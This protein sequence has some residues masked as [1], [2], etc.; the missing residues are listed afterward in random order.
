MT[1]LTAF[2]AYDVRGRIPSELNDDLAYRIGR[3]YAG[4]VAPRRVVVGRD[5]RLS[6]AQLCTALIRG[7]TESGVEVHDIGLCGTEGVYFATFDGGFDGGIM[8]TASHKPTDYNGMKFVRE[9]SKPISADSGLEQMAQAILTDQLPP[10]AA[11]PG[12]V[13][14]VDVNARY[15]AHLLSY[16]RPA[17]FA[18][19]KVVVNA[20][21]GGAGMVV[22]CL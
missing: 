4:F 21:N 13:V 8:V 11:V 5:I 22:D 17:T 9:L 1:P 2:K 14:Q 15:E 16:I 3:A 7:L 12:R 19:L 20:G 6:S 18:P 10:K